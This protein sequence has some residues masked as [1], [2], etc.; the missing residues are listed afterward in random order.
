MLLLRNRSEE[1]DRRSRTP[2]PGD[3]E[4]ELEPEPEPEPEPRRQETEHDKVEQKDTADEQVQVNGAD[5]GERKKAER[6]AALQWLSQQP[7]FQQAR[8]GLQQTLATPPPIQRP[9]PVAAPPVE[10]VPEV[11]V[12]P[13][14][15]VLE[16][17][18]EEAK[19]NAGPGRTNRMGKEPLL[20]QDEEEVAA[21]RV[22]LRGLQSNTAQPRLRGLTAAKGGAGGRLRHAG[23]MRVAMFRAKHGGPN[24]ASARMRRLPSRRPLRA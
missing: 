1:P 2:H 19:E 7:D 9:A 15:A 21:G 17:S 20:A 16:E 10:P 6:R 4:P 8:R 13:H 24:A 22:P 23:A 11:R 14:K 3:L 12:A 5:D 18:R